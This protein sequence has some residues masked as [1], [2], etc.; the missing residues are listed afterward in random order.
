[1]GTV[2]LLLDAGA[3]ADAKTAWGGTPLTLALLFDRSAGPWRTKTAA[4]LLEVCGLSARWRSAG[5][6]QRETHLPSDCN[7]P[8]QSAKRR[9]DDRGKVYGEVS[10]RR[11]LTQHRRFGA[12]SCK[13]HHVQAPSA[14]RP[15][16]SGSRTPPGCTTAPKQHLADCSRNFFTRRAAQTR[17]RSSAARRCCSACAPATR[18][19]R[20]SCCRSWRCSCAPA[21]RRPPALTGTRG[22]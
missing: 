1:V 6:T 7:L 12:H 20:R 21:P 10:V 15:S 13:H 22:A 8:G 9:S 16:H 5:A 14:L 3:D 18:C 11:R 4:R 2:G 19:P 17:M